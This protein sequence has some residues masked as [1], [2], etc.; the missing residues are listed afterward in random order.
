[1]V[2]KLDALLILAQRRD[3]ER[4]T[5]DFDTLHTLDEEKQRATAE[6]AERLL[7][8]LSPRQSY[9]PQPIHRDPRATGR[10]IRLKSAPVEPEAAPDPTPFAEALARTCP[11]CDAKPNQ[12]CRTYSHSPRVKP[13]GKRFPAAK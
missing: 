11:T 5:P 1:M 9:E 12:P 10:T 13:H 2:D 6:K 4:R 8:G 3:E 7:G